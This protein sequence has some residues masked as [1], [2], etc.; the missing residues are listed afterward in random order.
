MPLA[1]STG[2]VTT[3]VPLRIR[4]AIG[5]LGGVTANRWYVIQRNAEK[6]PQKID[7]AYRRYIEATATDIWSTMAAPGPT[8]Y[9]GEVI[10]DAPYAWWAM[11]D[12][13]LAGGVQPTVLRNSA[14]EHE[15]PDDHRGIRRGHRRGLLHHQRA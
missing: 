8:P 5:T 14:R 11:D 12:Q 9:R 15:H 13:P 2:L 7:A 1:V 10:Q 4:A 3:G 6:W